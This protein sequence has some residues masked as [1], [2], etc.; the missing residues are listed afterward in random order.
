MS[1]YCTAG[2][3]QH[4]SNLDELF[5]SGCIAGA[6]MVADLAAPDC[7]DG[8][9]LDTPDH[10]SHMS[11]GGYGSWG[12]YRCP[13]SHPY[14]I[15]RTENEV[16]WMVTSDMIGKRSDGTKFS[17]VRLSSDDVKPGA[18]PGETMHADYIEQWVKAAKDMWHDNCID[19]GLDCSGGDL[20]IGL[21]LVGAS[22]PSYG[23]NNP[24]LIATMP[25]P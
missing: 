4:Y 12:Y 23:L 22:Q 10:R 13:A 7:W 19:K 24:K 1:W 20:G 17:R 14:V 16:M 11:P 2:T 5:A 6:T 15:R 8:K 25:L 3:K 9:H 18:R 21:Q